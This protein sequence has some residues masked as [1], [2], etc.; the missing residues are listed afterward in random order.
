M[1]KVRKESLRYEVITSRKLEL[2]S[3]HVSKSAPFELV[4]RGMELSTIDVVTSFCLTVIKYCYIGKGI[5]THFLVQG[6][7]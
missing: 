6:G 3:S 7:F 5:M 1:T 4:A 2:S